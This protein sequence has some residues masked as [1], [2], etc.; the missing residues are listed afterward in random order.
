MPRT[1]TPRPIQYRDRDK[2][3][4]YVSEVARLTLVS[5]SIDGPSHLLIIRFEREGE[6]RLARWVGGD[7]WRERD[8]L[9]RLFA[10]AE[11]VQPR[12]LEK[13]PRMFPT[14]PTI[15][16]SGPRHRRRSRSG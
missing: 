5:A 11:E 8:A 16:A 1:H 12:E 9:H 4:W 13:P 14:P 7:E 10:A 3:V 15:P 2:R 6:E